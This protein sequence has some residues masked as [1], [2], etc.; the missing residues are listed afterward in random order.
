MEL[1]DEQQAAVEAMLDFIKKGKEDIFCLIG[2]AGTGKSFTIQHLIQRLPSKMRICLTAPTNKA[3]RVLK[4]LSEQK[5]LSVKC[6]TIHALLGLKVEARGGE[7]VLK[8]G[9]KNTI[10]DFDLVV[11]DEISM[12]DQVLLSYIEQAIQL[13]SVQCILMG[14]EAQLPPIG[15]KASLTFAYDNRCY[16]TK[17]VR[18]RKENPILALC[19]EIRELIENGATTFPT[20]LSATNETGNIGVHVMKGDRFTKWM[21]AAFSSEKF[22]GNFDKYRVVA[23]RNK[24]VDH[25]N[26]LIQQSRYGQLEAPFAI[27]EPI[28]FSNPLY[29]ISTDRSYHAEKKI[30]KGWDNILIQT[31]SEGVIEQ[32]TPI[33]PFYFQ[34]TQKQ[35]HKGLQFEP[36]V[37]SRYLVTCQVA[38]RDEPVNCTVTACSNVLAQLVSFIAKQVSQNNLDWLDYWKVKRL[39]TDIRPAYAMT[40]H[41]SQGSTFENVFVDADD[42]LDNPNREEALRCLY[43]AVSRASHNV[44]LNI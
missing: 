37:L 40:V 15:E 20:V 17:V 28:V 8:I 21:P 27:G 22:D 43:V 26:R 1:N 3:V 36:Y 9:G 42:I 6:T 34:P 12:I 11:I 16:L 4:H 25:Y 5:G 32:I 23:W 24:T 18:Q 35:S 14:D 33:E 44:V 38:G 7:E 19:C 39:F 29:A 2:P 31:E 41:K 10:S 30:L 13:E